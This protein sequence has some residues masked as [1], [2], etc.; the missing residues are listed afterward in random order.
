MSRIRSRNTKPELA[1]RRLL[2]SLG[3]RYR[4]HRKDLPGSPDIVF[5]S[6]RS[7]IFVHGCFWH[8]HFGCGRVPKSRLSYWIP[9]LQRNKLR[10]KRNARTLTRKGWKIMVI[11][12]CQLGGEK[13]LVRRISKFLEV[14]PSEAKPNR[15]RQ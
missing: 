3:Y 11:W 4:L 8:G 2:H 12:E 7:V 5:P 10:D 9:K 6:R 1:V 13:S 15:K 14:A